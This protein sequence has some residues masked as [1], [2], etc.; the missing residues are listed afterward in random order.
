MLKYA[1]SMHISQTLSPNWRA[2][3][4]TVTAFVT[5]GFPFDDEP[6]V[7]SQDQLIVAT[8]GSHNLRRRSNG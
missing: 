3:T 5:V 6:A 7:N 4:A 1:S 2:G 8:S